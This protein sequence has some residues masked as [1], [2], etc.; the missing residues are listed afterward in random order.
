MSPGSSPPPPASCA[1]CK[2]KD[3]ARCRPPAPCP[4][5]KAWLFRRTARTC[6]PPGKWRWNCFC[7]TTPAS[8]WRPARPAARPVSI[9]PA[10]STV[11]PRATTAAPCRRSPNAWRCPVL[12]GASARDSAK[13]AAAAAI[14]IRVWPSARCIG[15]PPIWTF[16]LATRICRR[17]RR[18][19]ERPWPSW[20]PGPRGSRPPGS[21]CG[22]ATPASCSTRIACRG[23]CSVTESPPIGCRR[24]RSTRRSPLSKGW[25]RDS[26]W[27]HAWAGTSRSAN[28]GGGTTRSFWQSERSAHKSSAARARSMPCPA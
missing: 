14:S 15:T 26:I 10:S 16:P 23:E 11:L 20:A 22:K 25:A 8:A 21:S 1:R 5:P 4:W 7:P 2:S 13:K 24:T 9:S 27:A 17:V 19:R 18:L 12:W 28:C 3:G 6:A